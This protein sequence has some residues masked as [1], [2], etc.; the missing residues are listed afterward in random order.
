MRHASGDAPC[1]VKPTPG[2]VIIGRVEPEFGMSAELRVGGF[3]IC[4][5]QTNITCRPG[6]HHQVSSP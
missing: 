5:S 3:F 6:A 4:S 1:F 2:T